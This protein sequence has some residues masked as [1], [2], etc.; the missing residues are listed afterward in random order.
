[1]PAKS[2]E[3]GARAGDWIETRA[4]TARRRAERAHRGARPQTTRALRVRSAEQRE[5]VRAR[6]V[7]GTQSQLR[8]APADRLP[9]SQKL[10]KHAAVAGSVLL[11]TTRNSYEAAAGCAGRFRLEPA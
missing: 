5:S 8:L 6:T 9:L 11:W 4:C 1:M 10:H 2:V 3:P 7:A